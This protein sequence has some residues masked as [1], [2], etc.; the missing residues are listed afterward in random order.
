MKMKAIFLVPKILCM[1]KH[2]PE[3]IESGINVFKI[4]GRARP[5]DY[6]TTVT[7]VY[8]EAIDSYEIGNWKFDHKWADELKKV[9]NR[10]FDTGFYF[11][12][13][14]KTSEYN[15]ATYIKKDIGS[16][17]NYYKNVSAAEIR[18]WNDLKIDDEI[19]IQGNKTGS[20]IQKVDSMQIEGEEIKTAEKGQNVGLLVKDKVRP[21][22]VVYKRIPRKN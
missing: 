6:V 20:I 10:G 9:F 17:V 1:I 4:E 14:F 8:R 3:L 7:S 21:N 12:T 15:E 5:A 11:K 19:I 18:L 13:P 22:D 16:V 2:I